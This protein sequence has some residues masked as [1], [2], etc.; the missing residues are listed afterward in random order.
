MRSKDV[1]NGEWAPAQPTLPG[2]RLWDIVKYDYSDVCTCARGIGTSGFIF[3]EDAPWECPK[4][5][6]PASNT[7]VH[8]PRIAAVSDGRSTE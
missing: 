8:D 5:V 7:G 4:S 3:C 1:S 6:P 2:I